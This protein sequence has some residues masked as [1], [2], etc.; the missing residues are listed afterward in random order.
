LKKSNSKQCR[1]ATRGVSNVKTN[2][3]QRGDVIPCDVSNVKT[4]LSQKQLF[5]QKLA[6]CLKS[7]QMQGTEIEGEGAY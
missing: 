3:Q 1:D 2:K 7:I 5:N 6:R 4:G